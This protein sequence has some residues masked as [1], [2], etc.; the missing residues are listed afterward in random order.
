MELDPALTMGLSL[1]LAA[2]FAAG[3][4]HKLRTPRAFFA[5]VRNYRLAPAAPA[6]G[7]AVIAAETTIAV[8]LVIPAWRQ[9]AALGA[10]ALLGI[11]GIA[12]A[13]NIMRGRTAIDCGCG[14]GGQGDRL[15]WWLP[16]RNA[17]LA[18]SALALTLPAASRA[19][20]WLDA[21][22]IGLFVA[23]A[24]VLYATF[25]ALRSN[26][27]RQARTRRPL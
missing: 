5:I 4:I 9:D 25:E 18:L 3:A 19:L 22:T 23:G 10:A 27:A 2:L 13:I 26:T 6:A 17:V 8:G 16:L 15:T 1:G 20:G 21:L 7:S 11:Y 14:F 24:A 12:I